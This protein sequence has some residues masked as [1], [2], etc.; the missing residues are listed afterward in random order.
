MKIFILT[1]KTTHHIY[2]VKKIATYYD[3]HTTILETKPVIPLFDTFHSFENDREI[4]ER[5]EL[6]REKILLLKN[7]V[8]RLSSIISIAR[9]VLNSYQNINQILL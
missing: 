9:G 5:E 8:K 4:Y 1:T 6:L 3:I 2:F 7:I